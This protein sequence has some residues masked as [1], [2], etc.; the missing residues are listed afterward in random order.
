MSCSNRCRQPSYVA[1]YP[2]H[3]GTRL[4]RCLLP[5]LG[6]PTQCNGAAQ[7]TASRRYS[8]LSSHS[9]GTRVQAPA[10]S[11]DSAWLCAIGSSMALHFTSPTYGAKQDG[12]KAS[13]YFCCVS[14]SSPSNCYCQIQVNT[15]TDKFRN[16]R[17]ERIPR[18][19]QCFVN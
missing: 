7:D 17:R 12:C 19:A 16:P 3:P 8:S 18:T 6:G 1:G 11:C 4:A 5:A 14:M 15:S 9:Y 2:Y 10:F 13:K